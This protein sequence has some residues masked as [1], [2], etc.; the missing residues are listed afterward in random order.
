MFE[1]SNLPF[2]KIL[3]LIHHWAVD[4][5]LN[6][7]SDLLDIA[8]NHVCEWFARIREVCEWFNL[9]NPYTVGGPG[10][11]VEIDESAVNKAHPHAG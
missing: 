5:P 10:L 9:A 8:Q 3:G 2:T 6:R 4:T 1:E 7:T 11:I